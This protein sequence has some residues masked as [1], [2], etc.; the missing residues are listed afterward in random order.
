MK[1]QFTT[2]AIVRLVKKQEITSKTG[3]PLTFVTLADKETYENQEFMLS[4]NLMPDKYVPGQDYRVVL[5]INGKY[6]DVELAPA[7]PK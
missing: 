2:S 1:M 4:R 3:K 6:S 5:N 7:P